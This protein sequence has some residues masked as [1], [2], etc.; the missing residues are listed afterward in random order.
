MILKEN[1]LQGTR[2][3]ANHI[4]EHGFNMEVASTMSPEVNIHGCL[5]ADTNFV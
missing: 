3:I 5:F 2:D 4:Y 1:Y